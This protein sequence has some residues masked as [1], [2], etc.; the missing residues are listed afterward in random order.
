MSEEEDYKSA[1]MKMAGEF[2]NNP[3]IKPIV[4]KVVYDFISSPECKKAFGE[5]AKRKIAE[6]LGMK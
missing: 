4:D 1:L 3:V 6:K 2:T 5:Y